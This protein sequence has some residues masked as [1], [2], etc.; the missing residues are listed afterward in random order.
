MA[1]TIQIDRF[2]VGPFEEN[3]YLLVGP[4]GRDAALVDPGGGMA[5]LAAGLLRI[6]HAGALASDPVRALRG[7]RLAADLGFQ[8][9]P[10]TE[11][12]MATAR[13]A[14]STVSPERSM[15]S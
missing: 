4:S 12:A 5:D 2:T 10:E 8:L 9:T 1:D 15:C 7:V 3:C 13:P 11:A 6:T 14:L